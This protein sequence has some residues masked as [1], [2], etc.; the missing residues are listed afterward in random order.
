[1]RDEPYFHYSGRGTGYWWVETYL[2]S[3]RYG[4]AGRMVQLG[5]TQKVDGRWLA[6]RPYIGPHPTIGS[7]GPAIEGDFRTRH[8]AALALLEAHGAD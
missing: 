7:L 3:G 2:R 5:K 8:E 1:M 4:L 6:W